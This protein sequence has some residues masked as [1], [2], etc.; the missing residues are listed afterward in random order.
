MKKGNMKSSYE[1]YRM[2]YY[3]SDVNEISEIEDDGNLEDILK[4]FNYL[5]RENGSFLVL[6]N[7]KREILQF[8]CEDDDMWIA[9]IPKMEDNGS[10]QAK[11]N[12]EECITLI[13]DFYNE[14][15]IDTHDFTFIPFSKKTLISRFHEQKKE[16]LILFSIFLIVILA[17]ST[18]NV[19]N[20]L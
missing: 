8:I 12:V 20:Y 14:I 17:I 9:D 19:W 11:L 2:K 5:S 3:Y 1:V 10:F 18:I 15:L 13:K 4:S 7:N 6:E 16:L